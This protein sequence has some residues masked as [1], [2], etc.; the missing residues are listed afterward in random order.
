MKNIFE[1]IEHKPVQIVVGLFIFHIVITC[2]MFWLANSIFLSHLHNGQGFWHFAKDSSLYHEEAI[3]IKNILNQGNWSNWD[4]SSIFNHPHVTWIAF[5][6]WLFEEETPLLF[7]AVNSVTWVTSVVLIYIATRII[8]GPNVRVASFAVLF[9]FFPSILLSS[10]QLLKD[11]FY[12]LGICFVI[13]GW[14]AIFREHSNLKGALAI[15]IGFLLITSIRSYVTYIVFSIFLIC[16]LVFLIRKK[17]AAVPALL[18]L[19]GIS[20][21]S[22]QYNF[23]GSLPALPEKKSLTSHEVTKRSTD[24]TGEESTSS[25]G[26]IALSLWRAAGEHSIENLNHKDG[27]LKEKL[28]LKQIELLK[29]NNFSGAS[30][31]INFLNKG[32]AIRLSIMRYG[33]SEVNGSANSKIDEMV[34]FMNIR[35]LFSYFPRAL[36]IGF[37]S[38]FPPLWVTPGTETGHIGRTIAGFETLIMYFIWVGFF[39]AVFM[40]MHILKPLAPVLIFSG[41]IIVL[42]GFV[43]PNVG[44]IYRMRQGLL[45]PFFMMGVYGLSLLLPQIK[46]AMSKYGRPNSL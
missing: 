2:M 22:F 30:G 4:F 32:I 18:M 28:H 37:L 27:A 6:Y 38:P 45:I 24:N 40:R 26:D 36:Q 35:E 42:L 8:C 23:F 21:I 9:L 33:F 7:E 41:V 10:T 3:Y 19:M 44:A 17:I 1:A 16:T 43:V 15:I 13:F 14:A 25:F 12:V 20:V 39:S 29:N 46:S 5:V 31:Y 34:Q 11:P